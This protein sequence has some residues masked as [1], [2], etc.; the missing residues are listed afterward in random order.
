MK[1]AVSSP[2][3]WKWLQK[4][5]PEEIRLVMKW[6]SAQLDAA[7]IKG[8]VE[9][10][11]SLQLGLDTLFAAMC[12][13]KGIPYKVFLAC[14]NQDEYWDEEARLNFEHLRDGA[15]DVEIGC[16]SY[17]QGC[18]ANQTNAITQYLKEADSKLL[19]VKNKKLSPSQLS[20]KK[21]LKEE[22]ILIY[23]M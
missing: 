20:R 21:E 22:Q 7:L 15:E 17:E 5:R 11:T 16:E 6:I 14:K 12:K 4:T 8:N 23:K 18:V 13:Q 2:G 3:G 19:L 10:V 1:I 9:G